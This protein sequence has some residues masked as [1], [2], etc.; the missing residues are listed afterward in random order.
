MAEIRKPVVRSGRNAKG[1]FVKGN[2]GGGRKPVPKEVREM[3]QAATTEAAQLLIDTM[4]DPE[5]KQN[6]RLDC[7]QEILNRVYGRAAQPLGGEMDAVIQIVLS[8]DAA[9]YAV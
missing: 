5:A 6:L 8:E 2:A 1:Q 4:R 7:A 9:E 3:L